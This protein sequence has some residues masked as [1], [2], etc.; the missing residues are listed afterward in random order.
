MGFWTVTGVQGCALPIW[1]LERRAAQGAQGVPVSPPLP[2]GMRR[3]RD[4][5]DAVLSLVRS[6]PEV[7]LS[8]ISERLPALQ[9]GGQRLDGKL[10]LVRGRR[11]RTR[12]DPPGT[13]AGAPAAGGWAPQGLEL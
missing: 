5:P 12:P 6:S 2:L 13:T 1:G 10:S 11:H 7:A 4:V 9:Q 8:R 3:R